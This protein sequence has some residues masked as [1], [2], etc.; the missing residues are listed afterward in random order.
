MLLDAAVIQTR[1][2]T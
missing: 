2:S 1:N